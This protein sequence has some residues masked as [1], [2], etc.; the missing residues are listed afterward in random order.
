M[1]AL[2]RPASR[3]MLAG[4]MVVAMR[5]IGRVTSRGRIGA[6]LR[7]RVQEVIALQ[8]GHFRTWGLDL[9]V[10]YAADSSTTA[11]YPTTSGHRVL[12]AGR[13][14]GGT[15]TTRVGPVQRS[16]SL[17]ARPPGARHAD[18]SGHVAAQVELARCADSGRTPTDGDWCRP[19]GVQGPLRSLA[20]GQALLLRPDAHIAAVLD[21]SSSGYADA[22]GAALDQLGLTATV[23]E[24]YEPT[25]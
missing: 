15:A 13:A 3:R 6:R 23:K 11:T 22:L 24:S 17:H 10:H 21:P 1:A 25:R 18:G 4:L 7:D 8:G 5:R 16:E 20:A 14:R 2:P 19:R 12:Y 9:G